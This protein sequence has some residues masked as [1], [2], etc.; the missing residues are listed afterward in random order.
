VVAVDDEDVVTDAPPA[1]P[2]I[3]E[4]TEYHGRVVYL[5][6]GRWGYPRGQHW[7]YYRREPPQLV[8]HRTYVQEAP[9]AHY[10]PTGRP[11]EAVRVR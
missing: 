6:N 3:Y 10:A 5:V 8:R 9:P 4:Q 2:T 7:Y 1:D 11:G